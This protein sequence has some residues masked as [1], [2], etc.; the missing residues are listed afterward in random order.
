MVS[1]PPAIRPT[2]PPATLIAAYTPIA[3]LRGG[4]SGKVVVISDSAVGGDD[5]GA[6]ALD[7]AGR[8]QP[9]LGGGEPAGQRGGGEQQQPGD[10]HLA[11]AEQVPGPAAEQQ[12]PAEGQRVGVDHP[13]QAGA[14]EAERALDVRQRDVDDGRVEHHH[15][16]RGGDDQ[17][18]QAEPGPAAPVAPGAA[19]RLVMGGAWDM[20]VSPSGF[21]PVYLLCRAGCAA[22]VP[23]VQA[24]PSRAG[25][26]NGSGLRVW[27]GAGIWPLPSARCAVRSPGTL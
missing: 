18:G 22:C 6:G 5:R 20:T 4:P 3:R 16:L 7:R 24:V 15:Q 12:Q 19:V 25:R 1:S 10:E 21:G 13:F 27:T 17:Q 14:G 9:G 8:Q 11:A 26:P 23:R 2:A